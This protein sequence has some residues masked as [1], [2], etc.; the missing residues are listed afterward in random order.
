MYIYFYTFISRHVYLYVHICIISV[1]YLCI[2]VHPSM[3]IYVYTFISRHVYQGAQNSFVTIQ[4]C[5]CLFFFCWECVPWSDRRPS[6][7]LCSRAQALP[8]P[9][10]LQ[11]AR[12][13]W[14]S[15]PCVCVCVCVRVCVCEC[16]C[17]CVSVCVC[18]Y[19]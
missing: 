15:G 3:H 10:K 17:V 13:P 14:S 19:R 5:L 6:C 1:T 2:S 12:A 9:W 7:S 4:F 16:V 11:A 18:L 8:G